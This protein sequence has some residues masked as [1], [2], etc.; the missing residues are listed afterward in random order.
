MPTLYDP[1]LKAT[2]TLDYAGGVRGINHL[3]Y[4]EME[5][6]RGRGAAAAYVRDIA[7]KL[8]I[9]PEAL[10]SLEQPVSYLDPRPQGV[11]YRFSEEKGSSDMATYAYYQTYLNTPVWAAGVTVTLKQAPARAVA[12]TNTSE[13]GIDAKLPSSESLERYRRLFATGEKIDGPPSRPKAKRPDAPDIA[14]SDLLAKILGEAANAPKG[15]DDTQTALRLIRGR[16]FVYRYDATKRTHDKPHPIDQQLCGTP[17]TLALPPVP[18][19]IHDGRWYLV[20]ELVFRLPYER[21]R[22]NWRMLVEVETN[23]ILYLRALTSGVVNGLVFTYDPIT[24]TGIATNTPDQSDAVLN[25]LRDPVELTNLNPPVGSPLT[26]SLDGTWATL[27]EIEPPTVTAPTRPDGSDFN[28]WDVHTNEF[29]AVNAYYH[30]DR[31]FQLVA[32]LGFPLT[33]TAGY[34]DGTAFPVEVDHRGLGN[35]INAH[36]IGDGDGIDHTC[37]ALATTSTAD[38]IGIATDWRVVL[39][40]LAGHGILHDHVG[41]PNF[42]FSHS[43]GDSFAVILNDYLSKWH[44][45]AALDRFLLAPFVPAI[46]RRSDRGVTEWSVASVTV[47]NGGT[48]YTSPPLVSL[49]GGGGTGATAYVPASAIVGGTVTFVVVANPGTGYASAPSV[50]FSGGGGT[51]AAA[52]AAIGTW[53]WGAGMDQGGYLSEEI[54]STTMFRVYR[55]IGGDSTSVNRREFAARCMARLMLRTVETLTPVSNPSSPAAFLTSLIAADKDDWTSEGVFG[56]AYGKVLTWAFAKQNLN[57]GAPPSVDVYIDDGRGGEYQY[58]AVH[59][60]TTTIWNR[61]KPDDKPNHQKPKLGQPN[62]AYVKIKNRGTQ[63]ANNVV[64][65]GYHCKPSAGVLWPNDLQPFTT[66]QLPAG[67]L[68]PNNT[69]E[70]TVGPFEWTPVANAWGH[71]CMLMIVSATGDLSNVDN[72]TAGEVFEDWR[73]VPNDNNIAQRNVIL[74]PGGGGLQDLAAELQG[75]GFWVGNPGRS[76]AKI[77]VSVTLPPLLIRRGWRI[78]LRGLPPDG[79]RLKAREQRLVTFEVHAG[80]PFTKADAEATTERDIIVTATADDAIIGGM[81]YRI[82]PELDMPFNER[83]PEEKKEACRGKAQQLLESLDVSGKKVKEARVRKVVIDVEM[84]D[85]G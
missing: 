42:G 18:T 6:L 52:T 62:Y 22:M 60:N 10:R 81:N 70:K 24:S 73:L 43:A 39:H 15:P 61:R 69:E 3:E 28:I 30:T 47:T 33:G 46:P 84:E 54:L 71:D 75:K 76:S 7:G 12:A 9:T 34:F 32:D 50:A 79:A 74:V 55:S 49:T 40:E 16:F 56:G 38:P 41:G 25:P 64:V 83:T 59:W 63:T 72:F 1:G 80:E 58:Q 48:G 65:R 14:S 21:H 2:V 36:C 19:S 8:N 5:N 11:E 66:P 29:A 26:Q 53:G 27:T 77:A 4:R 31:F 17:P 44:N 82:D 45:G 78:G 20:A 85:D 37:Y 35:K 57:N 51:G 68:Q 67:T 23:S 13:H